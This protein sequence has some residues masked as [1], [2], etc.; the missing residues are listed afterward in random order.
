MLMLKAMEDANKT[1]RLVS[2]TTTGTLLSM[3]ASATIQMDYV[4]KDFSGIPT[5]VNA[6]AK[7]K[8]VEKEITG[9]LMLL[10]E[11]TAHANLFQTTAAWTIISI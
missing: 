2:T 4:N 7:L 1:P 6:F 11:T 8:T 3:S 5:F 10:I 9:I